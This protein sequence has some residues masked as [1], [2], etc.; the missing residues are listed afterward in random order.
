MFKFIRRFGLSFFK[1]SFG[2]RSKARSFRSEP[3][4][5][6]VLLAADTGVDI[7]RFAMFYALSRGG[8]ELMAHV[9]FD[10]EASHSDVSAAVTVDPELI[11][12]DFVAAFSDGGFEQGPRPAAAVPEPSSLALVA[13]GMFAFLHRARRKA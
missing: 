10:Q 11:A 1:K 4:E 5:P 6:R 12:S 7:S 9:G 8:D 13:F 2:Q 3:L